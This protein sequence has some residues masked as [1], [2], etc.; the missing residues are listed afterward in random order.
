MTRAVSSLG[1][2]SLL[3]GSA[4]SLLGTRF[5]FAADPTPPKLLVCVFLRGAVD[6]LSLV[7]PHAE[8][9]YYAERPTI[10]IPR[11]KQHD[12]ALDLDGHFGLHPRLAR[13]ERQPAKLGVRSLNGGERAPEPAIAPANA[14]RR[15]FHVVLRLEVRARRAR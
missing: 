11:P 3:L 13:A 12:G 7:V 4:A 2:R 14:G 5:A 8:R 6:G 15:R 9:A 10:A 1:R